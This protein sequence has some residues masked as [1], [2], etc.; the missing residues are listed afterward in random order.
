MN[1]ESALVE[2]NEP[3]I[4][5]ESANDAATVKIREGDFI[6]VSFGNR[7]LK[8]KPVFYVGFVVNRSCGNGQLKTKFMRRADLKKTEEPDISLHSLSQVVLRLPHPVQAAGKSKRLGACVSFQDEN[9]AK[10]N[11]M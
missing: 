11:P 4:D 9:L 10:F 5:R 8:H 6:L 2:N 3:V 1:D 7:S